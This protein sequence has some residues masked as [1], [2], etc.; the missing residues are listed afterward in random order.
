M[1]T[2]A[3]Q[4]K[5][6]EST[7]MSVENARASVYVPV[8]ICIPIAVHLKERINTRQA[9]VAHNLGC[10]VPSSKPGHDM[11][12]R[13]G[14][15]FATWC[16]AAGEVVGRCCQIVNG[17]SIADLRANIFSRLVTFVPFD[18][19]NIPKYHHGQE[20]LRQWRVV[21]G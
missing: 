21:V 5:R 9:H 14:N 15:G 1:R 6:R 3:G 10:Y 4:N 19:R 20:R 18:D 12:G 7:V 11:A 13:G 16:A 2:V 17:R 8:H